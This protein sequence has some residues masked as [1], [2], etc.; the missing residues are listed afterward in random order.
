[1]FWA[2]EGAFQSIDVAVSELF[3]EDSSTSAFFFVYIKETTVFE[4]K[5]FEKLAHEKWELLSILGV[6]IVM[7]SINESIPLHRV[8]MEVTKQ[9]HFSNFLDT[10]DQFFE[11]EDLRVVHFGGVFPFTIEIITRNVR[12]VVA[13]NDSIRIKHRDNFEDEVL[14]QFS[15]L[16][17]VRNQELDDA[18]ADIR[19]HRLSRVDSGS[20]ND[21]P[22]VELL[23]YVN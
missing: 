7:T 8:T 9:D 6:A 21:V 22:L 23:I 18:V 10:E 4:G 20:Y 3:A 19:T 15:S 5:R 17:T 13:V 16:V 12:P 14:P 2:T 11:V 1:M